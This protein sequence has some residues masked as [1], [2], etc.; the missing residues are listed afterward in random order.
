MC[1]FCMTDFT[2]TFNFMRN[3]MLINNYQSI[4]GRSEMNTFQA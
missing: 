3:N 2:L 4:D 1:H